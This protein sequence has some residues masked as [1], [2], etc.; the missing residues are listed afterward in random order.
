MKKY[1]TGGTCNTHGGDKKGDINLKVKTKLSL[2]F[3]SAPH[4]DGVL[5]SG[6]IAPRIN[7]GTIWR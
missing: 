6:G 7:L 2:C 5:G 3:N 4:H 1:E